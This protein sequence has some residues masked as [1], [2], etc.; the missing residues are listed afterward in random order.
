MA[1]MSVFL[2]HMKETWIE[3]LAPLFGLSPGLADAGIEEWASRCVSCPLTNIYLIYLKKLTMIGCCDFI[4]MKAWP[5]VLGWGIEGHGLNVNFTT[6]E[7]CCSFFIQV[8]TSQVHLKGEEKALFGD[9]TEFSYYLC[10][11]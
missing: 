11:W 8:L 4:C 6:K 3:S 5:G 10:T 9:K 7:L 2:L 1:P